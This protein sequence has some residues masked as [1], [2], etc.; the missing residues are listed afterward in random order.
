MPSVLDRTDAIIRKIYAAALEPALWRE[1]SHDVAEA[2][3][4]GTVH[5]MLVSTD[6]ETEYLS[7]FERGDPAFA[8]VY[9]ADYMAGDFRVPRVLAQAPGRL[10]D[11]RSYVTREEARKSPIHQELLPRFDIYNI[12][13]AHMSTA[14]TFGWFG[15]STRPGVEAFDA[16]QWG[17]LERLIPHIQ[18][19]Y[20]ILK[21]NHDLRAAAA[22]ARRGLDIVDAAVFHLLKGCILE[23]N[24]AAE[25]LLA[26]GFFCLRDGRLA[27]ADALEDRKIAA[28]LQDAFLQNGGPALHR[29]ALIHDHEREA[30]YFLRL[31][32]PAPHYNGDGGIHAGRERLLSIHGSS[33]ACAPSLEE[34][35]SFCRSHGLTGAETRVVSGVLAGRS[36]KEVAAERNIALDTVQKQLKSAMA[37]AGAGSQKHLFRDFERYRM[38]LGG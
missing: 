17:V 11:E 19:S 5:L 36:L 13:G 2:V 37:K 9:L 16:A 25:N 26:E 23:A 38:L 28:F 32:A 14:E 35:V 12:A 24:A 33:P 27:C 3:G 20:A 21:R 4:G 18:Q 7:L 29:A 1:V 6:F 15:V 30:A 10:V 31:H 22:R 34:T 8:E